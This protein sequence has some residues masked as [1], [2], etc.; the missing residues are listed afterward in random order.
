M[1]LWQSAAATYPLGLV[2]ADP[3]VKGKKELKGDTLIAEVEV[4]GLE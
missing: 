4:T 2:E 3:F 1:P